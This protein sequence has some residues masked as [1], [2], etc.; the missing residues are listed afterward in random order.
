MHPEQAHLDPG[1][2]HATSDL[3][4]YILPDLKRLM[5]GVN[6]YVE[7]SWEASWMQSLGFR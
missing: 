2:I 6:C 5:A 7:K 3:D 1:M 4:Q